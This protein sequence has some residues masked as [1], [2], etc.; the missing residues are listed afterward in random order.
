MLVLLYDLMSC[1]LQLVDSYRPRPCKH[2]GLL[3]QFYHFVLSRCKTINNR[4]WIHIYG[5]VDYDI[6]CSGTLV[7]CYTYIYMAACIN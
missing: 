2:M 1:A 6:W 3:L 5:M 4:L 7:Y